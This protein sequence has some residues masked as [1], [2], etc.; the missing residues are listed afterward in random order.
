MR[1][2]IDLPDDLFREAKTR[3]AQQ[4][5]TLKELMTQF[6]RTG[7]HGAGTSPAKPRRR[8]RPPVAIASVPGQAPTPAMT[9]RQ[10]NELLE[11]QDLPDVSGSPPRKA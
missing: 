7:L 10:L 5:T 6:I 1:T 8:G 2:T 11:A 3:A 4:G 9:N